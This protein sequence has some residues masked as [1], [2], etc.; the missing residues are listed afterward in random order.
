[1]RIQNPR[2]RS[3]ATLQRFRCF[4]FVFLAAKFVCSL[5]KKKHVLCFFSSKENKKKLASKI[6]KLPS[7]SFDNFASCHAAVFKL[8]KNVTTTIATF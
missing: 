5:L 7:E 4:F 6:L 3:C 2:I 8:R 1:M